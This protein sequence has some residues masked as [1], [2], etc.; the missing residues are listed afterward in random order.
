VRKIESP[1][2][3]PQLPPVFQVAVHCGWFDG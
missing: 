1:R 3:L 2:L